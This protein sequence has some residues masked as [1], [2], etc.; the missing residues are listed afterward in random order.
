M[1]DKEFKINFK[2]KKEDGKK[3]FIYQA[4]QAFAIWHNIFPKIDEKVENLFNK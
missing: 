1:L 2:G 4:H 3:M